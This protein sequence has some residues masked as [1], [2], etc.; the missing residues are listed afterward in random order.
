[1]IVDI[2]N[3]PAKHKK[4]IMKADKPFQFLAACIEYRNYLNDPDNFVSR[5]PVAMDGV[6]NGTQHWCAML[7]DKVGGELVALL[8]SSVPSDLYTKVLEKLKIIVS[9]HG[10][11]KS[12][13][14]ESSGAMTRKLVKTP[15]MTI[16]YAAGKPA[17]MGHVRNYCIDNGHSFSDDKVEQ[18]RYVDYMVDNIIEAIDSTVSA[19]SGMKFVQD[20]VDGKLSVEWPTPIGFYPYMQPMRYFKREFKVM[21]N[22][23]VRMVTF[24]FKSDKVDKMS[25]GTG[26]APNFVHS[27]DATH[28]LLTV[29]SLPEVNSWMMVHDSYATLATDVKKMQKAIREQ[30]VSLYKEDRLKEFALYQ[31]LKEGEFELPKYGDLDI[32][33]IKKS[34]YFFS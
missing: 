20:C 6:C 14:W 29:N 24:S 31:G 8:N 3:N 10:T 16:T 18:N 19:R 4:Y 1:M 11:D 2:A 23:R 25:I 21:V 27:M 12:K 28:M 13:A 26:I 5:L 33:D 7:R 32:N 30:F 17:F 34:K 9:S 22:G 15:T